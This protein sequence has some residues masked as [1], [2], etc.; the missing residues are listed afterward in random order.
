MKHKPVDPQV[1]SN[2]D[3]LMGVDASKKR[4][5]KKQHHDVKP[6]T[7]EGLSNLMGIDVKPTSHDKQLRGREED[8]GGSKG[9]GHKADALLG[10]EVSGGGQ[11]KEGSRGKFP[12]PRQL[13]LSSR[14]RRR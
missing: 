2:L 9:A 12:G 14:C 7:A 8:R 11:G 6:K 1:A 10:A 13:G 5:D 4:T 3:T